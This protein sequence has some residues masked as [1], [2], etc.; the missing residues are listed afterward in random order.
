MTCA[1]TYRPMPRVGA[2]ARRRCARLPSGGHGPAG[3]RPVRD[4]GR[5]HRGR[6][7][8]ARVLRAVLRRSPLGL[9]RAARTLAHAPCVRVERR[10]DPPSALV[11]LTRLGGRRVARLARVRRRLLPRRRVDRR[12]LSRRDRGLLLPTRDGRHRSPR[13]GARAP[14]G[15]RSRVRPTERSHRQAKHHR[16]VPALGLHRPRLEPRRHLA[17]GPDRAHGPR[18]DDPPEGTV[19]RG[20]RDPGDPLVRRRPRQRR[21]PNGDVAHVGSRGCR[22]ERRALTRRGRQPSRVAASRRQPRPLV[23]A[24]ARGAAAARRRRRSVGRR[25]GEPRAASADGVPVRDDAELGHVGER[26]AALPQGRE[27]RSDAHGDRR[28]VSGRG[29]A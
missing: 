29:R 25:R 7:Q 6:A 11:R 18:P 23:A 12:H 16:R 27:P 20:R 21:G 15:D 2:G 17:T 10:A 1:P 26:R 3:D 19:P 22:V 4:V 9:R 8:P 13:R 24:C 5:D 14:A 28:G